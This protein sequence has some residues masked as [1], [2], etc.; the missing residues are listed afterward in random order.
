M[1]QAENESLKTRYELI[2]NLSLVIR[3]EIEIY[4]KFDSLQIDVG[5]QILNISK[6]PGPPVSCFSKHML[7]ISAKRF[8]GYLLS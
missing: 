8:F 3:S 1:K 6:M 2:T 7:L 4:Q 5:R